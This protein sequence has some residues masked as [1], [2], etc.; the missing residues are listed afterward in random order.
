MPQSERARPILCYVTDRRALGAAN[1]EAAC[2]ALLEKIRDA[3]DA[4]VDWVQIR[5][6]DLEGR[7]LA[8]L[9]RAAVESARGRR[10]IVNDRLDVAIAAGAA[11]VHLGGES[12][13]VAAVMKWLRQGHVPA[14]FLV[15]RS[16][17]SADEAVAAEGDGADYVFFGPVFATPSK[18][19]YGAP[20]GIAKLQEVCRRVRIP[21]LAIGGVTPENAEECV[22]AAAAGIAAIR[23][24]QEAENL[25]EKISHLRRSPS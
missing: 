1:D 6:K 17:H 14:D 16:C 2:A 25:A 18:A 12:L 20:Q 9:V 23:M 7:A 5:E 21:V 8:N 3:L 19:K 24:F 13:P 15:G 4:G 11:G 22:Q 10:I